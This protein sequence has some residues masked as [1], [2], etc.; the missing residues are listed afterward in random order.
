MTKMYENIYLGTRADWLKISQS[1][2][3]NWAVLHACASCFSDRAS[4]RIFQTENELFLNWVDSSN[5]DDF[6]VE[7]FYA[8]FNF[9]DKWKGSHSVLIHCDYG[10][11]RSPSLLMAYLALRQQSLPPTFFAALS[12]F[13][14]LCPQHVS[15]SGI[16]KFIKQ[17][18]DNL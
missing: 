9:I 18:W 10:Q 15:P 6:L 4:D 3:S 7:E 2:Y 11:S 5:P 1:D 12:E 14:K 8:A 17:E 16:L 13:Q